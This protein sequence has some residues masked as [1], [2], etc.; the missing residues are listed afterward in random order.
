MQIRSL[1]LIVMTGILLSPHPRLVAQTAPCGIKTLKLGGEKEEVRFIPASL[2]YVKDS[3]KR[4]LPSVAADL[5]TEQ[6]GHIE[7]KI[8]VALWDAMKN[9]AFGSEGIK[10]NAAIG[11]LHIDLA[12]ASQDGVEGTTLKISFSKHGFGNGSYGGPLADETEC[13]VKLL[14]PI[15]PTVH[16]TGAVSAMS[17]TTGEDVNVKAGTPVKVALRD[18]LYSIDFPKNASTVDV[19]LQVI[20]DVKVSGVTVVRKGALAKGK[21]TDWKGPKSFSRDAT[22][23]FVVQSVTAV[24][25]QEIPLGENSTVNNSS[26]KASVAES[27]AI[28]GLLG[29][30]VTKGKPLFVRAGTSWELPTSKDLSIKAQP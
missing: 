6:P 28:G 25:G 21:I 11:V 23:R 17:Q 18:R 22:L 19:V 10:S 27:I 14:S 2:D 3:V 4:A 12:T 26:S 9:R 16:P 24:D 13:L 5:K 7:A 8:D 29:G 1:S 30:L 20:E 15:D